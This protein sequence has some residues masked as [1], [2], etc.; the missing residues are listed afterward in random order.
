[1]GGWLFGRCDDAM[2]VMISMSIN[3]PELIELI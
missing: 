1:M 2:T 3:G